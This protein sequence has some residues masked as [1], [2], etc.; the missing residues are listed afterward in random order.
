MNSSIARF[1]LENIT[2]TIF[3]FFYSL[4]FITFTMASLGHISGGFYRYFLLVYA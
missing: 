3:A 1:E 4:F 2:M